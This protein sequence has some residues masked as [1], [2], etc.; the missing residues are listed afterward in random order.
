MKTRSPH[1]RLQEKRQENAKTPEVMAA[2]APSSA[3]PS[4]AVQAKPLPVQTKLEVGKADDAFEKEADAVAD[5][6]VNTPDE[7]VSR[8]SG[9]GAPST[10]AKMGS[11]QRK[12]AAGPAG[13]VLRRKP[14]LQR[15]PDPEIEETGTGPDIFKFEHEMAPPPM[16]PGGNGIPPFNP[17]QPD[18]NFE[19]LLNSTKGRGNSLSTGL[20]GYMEPRIGAD[21]SGVRI[22]TG[23]KAEQL[24]QQLGS[25]AF[26]HGDDVYFN[27]G[28][29]D[30]GSREGKR[31]IAHEL[32]HTVQQGPEKA[33]TKP[34]ATP[35]SAAPSLSF[36]A[37]SLS[38]PSFSAPK[39]QKFR[40]GDIGNALSSGTIYIGNALSSGA[41]DIGNSLSSRASAI[42]GALSSGAEWVGDRVDDVIELGAD[43]LMD[44]VRRVAPNLA[45]L[46][47][48]GPMG[49][50]TEALTS[51]IQGWLSGIFGN[52]GI[53]E[54]IQTFTNNFA[55]IFMILQ[56]VA[57][58]DE[59]CC[60][61]FNEAID[62][63]REFISDFMDNPF[64]EAI[65][66]AFEQVSSIL[67]K[68]FNLVMAPIF[69]AIMDIAG[70]AFEM[71]RDLAGTISGWISS[72]KNS[73]ERAWNWVM[74]QLGIASDGE[75]GI[76]NWIKG[77]AAEVW[78]TV[79]ETFEPIIGPLQTVLS[80]LVLISPLRPL[81]VT[82]R[83]GP[84]LVRA[85]QWL[86]A[87]KD[88][89]NII[90]DAREEMGDTILP[91][92]LEN[93]QE[94]VNTLG[95]AI[96]SFMGEV[97]NLGS[98]LLELI[99]GLTGIPLL[100]IVKGW[101]ETLSEKV[102][103]FIEWGQE[104]LEGAVE[105]LTAA[106][107]KIRRVVEPYIEILSSIGMAILNPG[108]IPVI[109]AGWAWRALDDCYKP[110]IIDFLLDGIIGFLQRLP[111][112]PFLGP[113]WSLFKLFVIGFMQGFRSR[114]DEEKID[115]TNKLA[116]IIA[117]GSPGFIRGFVKGFLQGIWEG[118]TDPFVLIF[119][120]VD[121]LNKLSTWFYGL[122]VGDESDTE[123]GQA[124]GEGGGEAQPGATPEL[125]DRMVEMG[126]ELSEPIGEVTENFVPAVEEH[127]SAGEGMSFGDLMLKMSEMWTS[128]QEAIRGAGESLSTSFVEM[129]L[130]D[131]AESTMGEF[132]GWLAGTIVF[133][134]VLEILTFGTYGIATTIAKALDWTGELLG[135]I[136]KLLG[137]IGKAIMK[138]VDKLAEMIS[139]ATGAVRRV[140]D[141]L[142]V[143]GEKVM[144]FADELMSSFGRG[145]ASEVAEEVTEEIA[146]EVAE[147]IAEEAVEELAEEVAEEIAEEA[148]E[149]AAEETAEQIGEEAAEETAEETA[150][151]S[152]EQLAARKDVELPRALSVAKG[153]TE[154][155]DAIGTPALATIASLIGIVKPRYRWIQTFE[156]RPVAPGRYTIHM[157]A[158]DHEVDGNY[159][160]GD[161]TGTT[162]RQTRFDSQIQTKLDAGYINN[163]T[164]NILREYNQLNPHGGMSIDHVISEIED[165]KV[166]NPETGRFN[167]PVTRV[168]GTPR[169]DLPAE[170]TP[171]FQRWEDYLKNPRHG[172]PCF[173]PGT[174]VA[175]PNG[176][177]AIED[178]K[179][180]DKI[181]SFNHHTQKTQ[182]E[183]VTDLFT[184]WGMYLMEIQ[185]G[186]ETISATPNHPFWEETTQMYHRADELKPG[187]LLR[188]ASGELVTISAIDKILTQTVTY[189]FTAGEMHNYY[190]GDTRVLVHNDEV[191]VAN[192]ASKF[193][194]T[195]TY[196]STVY[197]LSDGD[198]VIYVGQSVEPDTRFAHHISDPS[199]AVF[200]YLEN[201]GYPALTGNSKHL[202]DMGLEL[203]NVLDIDTPIDAKPLTPYELTVWE[204]HHIDLNNGIDNL[205][206]R[207]N[208]ITPDKREMY[209]NLHN[210]C[211]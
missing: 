149:E 23:E 195:A 62:S 199:S 189:N 191:D 88:N 196:P 10:Q 202:A 92:L 66:G 125:R 194:D 111:D 205:E 103:S 192:S 168:E 4:F 166:L 105:F 11:V 18:G 72:V 12:S 129:L 73:M 65:K 27:K 135:V 134:V 204:Q 59:E 203:E 30:P 210:P 3:P 100:S 58:G 84:G 156:A 143:I 201:N 177:V 188:L 139:H 86:W 141:A 42:G 173:P 38:A 110:P 193:A 7:G 165:R 116:L 74:E 179:V 98:G 130:S 140:M 158:S 90:E 171:E 207:I 51:G 76:W 163:E 182:L 54:F 39:I 2:H 108:M 181:W 93:G 55:H 32:T 155:N 183:V 13:V 34:E 136:F 15:K 8:P 94:F 70:S 102:Q 25:Q 61:A 79:K 144:R 20:R 178:L 184:N 137:K 127:F 57:E 96:S 138:L 170:G 16:D 133:E 69:D 153:I 52:L 26:A 122:I 37:P 167:T 24:N 53:G 132:I 211:R 83:Y 172:E 208:A 169:A 160:E 145:A 63:M 47:S 19:S 101:I 148:T 186:E 174:P 104:K 78:N 28:K 117:G 147:E 14:L 142:S 56:G 128:A 200:Q 67:S 121:G 17:N 64:F 187:H 131:E 45:T 50:I 95:T 161:G 41:S 40:L 112:L 68:A 118:L 115:V 1:L 120:I 123:T 164:A 31:L 126:D 159:T 151:E 209:A 60:H 85:I 162:P 75:D 198:N 97:V 146:E 6:V 9:K 107:A 119:Q 49:M 206:N 113:L 176:T 185:V 33:R 197:V 35:S 89:P 44:I 46:I 124:N 106:V 190:V 29:Y 99:G 91:D 82:V 36:S 114:T 5:R 150:E 157:I 175:T 48:E 87:N 43:A 71:V 81:V 22:H 77:I 80:V 180:N 152:A 154:A 21:F 109:L